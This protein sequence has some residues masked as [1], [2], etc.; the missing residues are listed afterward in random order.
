[1]SYLTRLIISGICLYCSTPKPFH[2]LHPKTPLSQISKQRLVAEVVQQR[3]VVNSQQHEL[4]LIRKKIEE[5]AKD[6]LDVSTS[7]QVIGKKLVFV[8]TFV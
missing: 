4:D 8:V 6:N 3:K 5:A 7:V 2:E 1:M